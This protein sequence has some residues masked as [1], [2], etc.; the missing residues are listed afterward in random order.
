M[1][2]TYSHTQEDVPCYLIV[3]DTEDI[4]ATYK[5]LARN[6]H[7]NILPLY[8]GSPKFSEEK[9]IYGIQIYPAIDQLPDTLYMVIV[10]SD[11]IL[12]ELMHGYWKEVI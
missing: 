6:K 8:C 2:K 12:A 9:L 7:S 4:K 10:S 5:S 3:G 11:V 1:M